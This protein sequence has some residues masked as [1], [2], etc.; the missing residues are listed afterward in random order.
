MGVL[1]LGSLGVCMGG[2]EERKRREGG[3]LFRFIVDFD[4]GFGARREEE[5]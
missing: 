2:G 1:G 4:C 5:S 3:G